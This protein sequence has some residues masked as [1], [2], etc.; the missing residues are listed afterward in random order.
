L[1]YKGKLLFTCTEANPCVGLNDQGRHVVPYDVGGWFWASM[2]CISN[3]KRIGLN[4]GYGNDNPTAKAL[5]DSLY[6]DGKLYRMDA[7]VVKILD[8]KRWHFSTQVRY[9]DEKKWPRNKINLTF[10]IEDEHSMKEDYLVLKVDF[11]SVYGRVSGDLYYEGE[12]IE[13]KD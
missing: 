9:Q 8:D 7:T 1:A 4:F 2:S 11:K 5:D 13:I 10:V 3:G 6:I 12:H